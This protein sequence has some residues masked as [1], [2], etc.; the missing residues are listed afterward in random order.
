MSVAKRIMSL[1]GWDKRLKGR[2]GLKKR[3]TLVASFA[4]IV[5]LGIICLI[6]GP[7]TYQNDDAILK[8]I[9]SGTYTGKSDAHLIYMMY[10]YGLVLKGLYSVLPTVPWYDIMLTVLHMSVWIIIASRMGSFFTSKKNQIISS[11]AAVIVLAVID[12]PFVAEQHYTVIAAEL[13]A[14]ALFVFATSKKEEEKSFIICAI[15]CYI[16]GLW[17]RKQVFLLSIP[18][19]ALIIIYKS[20][21]QKRIAQIGALIAIFLLAIMSYTVEKVAYSEK[22]WQDFLAYNEARTAVYD[23]WNVPAF[24]GNEEFFSSIGMNATDRET[25]C[26]YNLLLADEKIGTD[27]LNLIAN[28]SKN[29]LYGNSYFTWLEI[30]TFIRNVFFKN[31]IYLEVKP[32]GYVL[33]FVYAWLLTVCICRKKWLELAFGA[34]VFA[35]KCAVSEFFIFLRRFPA[36]VSYGLLLMEFVCVCAILY[37]LLKE[38]KKL[39]VYIKAILIVVTA[40]ISVF[41]GIGVKET[42]HYKQPLAEKWEVLCR[43][44]GENPQTDFYIDTTLTVTWSQY[45]FSGYEPDNVYRNG[46]WTMHSPLWYD[47]YSNK[48]GMSEASYVM[49]CE[50][51]MEWLRDA[52]GRNPEVYDTIEFEDGSIG[53]VIRFT[54]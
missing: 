10:M 12:M 36:R 7:M 42:A 40:T 17:L 1:P 41:S 24:E 29:M 50:R 39:P 28:Q 6:F 4:A 11:V 34:L 2:K 32:I 16:F 5:C 3:S 44:V 21:K 54:D 26:S 37:E 51:S 15:V 14:G 35:Y 22:E 47:R 38:K 43:Y 23:Y 20:V 19:L 31:I 45:M 27:E 8:S 48:E 18:I 53:N 52:F 30:K 33:L 46:V 13:I 25:V 9:A 49:G